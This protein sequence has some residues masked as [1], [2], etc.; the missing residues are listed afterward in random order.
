MRKAQY[1]Q[2][3]AAGDNEP[4]EVTVFYFGPESGG[5]VGANLDR[6]VGQISGAE[7]EDASATAERREYEVAGLRIHS[8]AV[9]GNYDP[10]RGRPMGGG[11]G[12]RPGYR[13][14][15]VVVEAPEGNVFF[16]LT[17]PMA[18][19][20]EMEKGLQQLVQGLRAGC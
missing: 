19:A 15:G 2:P 6:W 17:G 20:M 3:P 7:G 16:K 10:G 5:G 11:G 12:A 8:V 4:A 1:T 13:L 9:N 18:T 14:V